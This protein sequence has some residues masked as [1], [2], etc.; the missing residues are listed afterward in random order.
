MIFFGV[1]SLHR[2]IAQYVADYHSERNHQ[3]LENT[4][5]KPGSEVGVTEGRVRRRQRLGGMLSYYYR[6]AA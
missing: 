5:I 1:T 4:I 2:A 6:P 3:G